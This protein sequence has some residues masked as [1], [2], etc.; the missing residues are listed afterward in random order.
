MLQS[1][2]QSLDV[3]VAGA[4]FRMALGFFFVPAFVALTPDTKPPTM[5]AALIGVLF[6]VKVIAALGRRIVPAS[7]L[8]RT[9]WE[10]RRDLARHHDS[11]QWRKLLWVGVGLL[12]G[13][14]LGFPGLPIQWILGGACVLAGSAAEIFWR[15]LALPLTPPKR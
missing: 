10:W 8:V 9:H 11:Y 14:A 1:I 2:L 6:L 15:R 7:E 5:I 13:A 3:G 4:S 12:L